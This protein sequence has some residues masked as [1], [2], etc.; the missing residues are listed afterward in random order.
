MRN[1]FDATGVFGT[2]GADLAGANYKLVFTMDP[3]AGDYSTFNGS[4]GSIFDPLVG[5]QIF[6]GISAA[7]TIN[8][9]SYAFPNMGPGANSSFEIVGTAPGGGEIIQLVSNVD[10]GQVR[11]W[12]TSANPGPGFPTSVYTAVALSD[13]PTGMC[14]FIGSFGIRTSSGYFAGNL[15]FGSLTVTTTPIPA[16]LPL[17]ASGLG[18]LGF[19]GWRRPKLQTV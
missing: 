17:L 6:N 11:A 18:G 10:V 5:D 3:S 14:S 4:T 8:G 16:A 1:A 13:C 15:N 9:N 2:P 7:L 12:I 19:V